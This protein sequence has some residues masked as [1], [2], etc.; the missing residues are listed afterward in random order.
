M[1]KRGFVGAGFVEMFKKTL[2]GVIKIA[3]FNKTYQ[4]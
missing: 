3:F 4:T 1:Q 2:F